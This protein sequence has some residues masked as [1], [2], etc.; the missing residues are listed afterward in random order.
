VATFTLAGNVDD[1]TGADCARVSEVRIRASHRLVSPTGVAYTLDTLVEADAGAFSVELPSD[2]LPAPYSF[3]VEA[4]QI[5]M[6][7]EVMPGATGE[8]KTLAPAPQNTYPATSDPIVLAARPAGRQVGRLTVDPAYPVTATNFQ[9]IQAAV[10]AGKALQDAA[11]QQTSSAPGEFSTKGS[12]KG[13]D[14]RVDVVIAAGTYVEK[15][16]GDD[17]VNLIG[18]TGDP[19]DVVIESNVTAGI[20]GVLHQFGPGYIE[21]ITLRSYGVGAADT[22]PKYPLHV[23]TGGPG[24]FVA[25]NCRFTSTNTGGAGSFGMDGGAGLFAYFYGCAFSHLSSGL[26]NAHGGSG[27]TTPV[28]VVWEDCTNNGPFTYDEQGAATDDIWLIDSTPATLTTGGTTTD[29]L[30]GT[31]PRP[32]G[33][34]GT[35]GQAYYYPEDATGPFPVTQVFGSGDQ[36]AFS[37]PNGRI[38]YVPIDITTAIHR[39]H[40]GIVAAS[41]GGIAEIWTKRLESTPPPTGAPQTRSIGTLV[42]GVNEVEAYHYDTFYPGETHLYAIVKIVSGSPSLQGSLTLASGAYYSD[43]NGTTIT[44]VPGATRVPVI[45]LRSDT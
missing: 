29:R 4:P 17:Y 12:G 1:L 25:V 34:L 2:A 7:W 6:S 21:G 8:T 9:T 3:T 41:A 40:M 30:T 22:G 42:S 23:T 36:A 27:N 35:G 10:D 5:G 18:A 31:P 16:G 14:Y 39:T 11:L 28:V 43:N 24:A 20:T 13:P 37:P 44:A 19:A 33:A 38:Y 32:T 15:V 45:R 26:M